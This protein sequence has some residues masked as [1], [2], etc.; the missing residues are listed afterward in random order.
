[1]LVSPSLTA[2]LAAAQC[3]ANTPWTLRMSNHDHFAQTSR[4]TRKW[5]A[6]VKSATIVGGALA[7]HR[8]F[9]VGGRYSRHSRMAMKAAA[10]GGVGLAWRRASEQEIDRSCAVGFDQVCVVDAKQ[11]LGRTHWNDFETF[12]GTD[13]GDL[14]SSLVAS[15]DGPIILVRRVDAG[16]HEW[17]ILQEGRN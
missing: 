8:R 13:L 9:A 10:V 14:M 3:K 17:P 15:E 5:T 4:K 1:M 16:D 12:A 7:Q 11:L 6:V 2:T